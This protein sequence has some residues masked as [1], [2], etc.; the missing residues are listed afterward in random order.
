MVKLR[1]YRLLTPKGHSKNRNDNPTC[2]WK[3]SFI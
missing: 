3:S 2:K 1:V